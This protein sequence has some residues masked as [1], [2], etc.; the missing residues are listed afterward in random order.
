MSYRC[1]KGGK[2]EVRLHRQV[3][4]SQATRVGE[5]SSFYV[6]VSLYLYKYFMFFLLKKK[7]HIY[8]WICTPCATKYQMYILICNFFFFFFFLGSYEFYKVVVECSFCFI[9]Y[10][11]KLQEEICKVVWR[12]SSNPNIDEGLSD[13]SVRLLMSSSQLRPTLKYW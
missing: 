1:P 12:E 4:Y 13:V 10:K 6:T 2:K 7:S 11:V 9:F 3:Q 8:F 5:L